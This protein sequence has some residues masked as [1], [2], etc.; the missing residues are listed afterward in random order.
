MLATQ[1]TMQLN[2]YTIFATRKTTTKTTKQKSRKISSSVKKKTCGINARFDVCHISKLFV[3]LFILI[4][5]QMRMG[6]YLKIKTKGNNIFILYV[7]IV[8]QNIFLFL[9][10]YSLMLFFSSSSLFVAA[11]ISVG[12]QTTF[13]FV[14]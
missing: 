13:E 11:I 14:M 1:S 12:T 5:H 2:F 8:W 6:F 9:V 10:C 3:P 4:L 7:W